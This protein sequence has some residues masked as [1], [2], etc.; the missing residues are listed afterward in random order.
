MNNCRLLQKDYKK[1]A[2][3]PLETEKQPFDN[4]HKDN[5]KKL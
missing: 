5:K 4:C 2:R 1:G 3:S